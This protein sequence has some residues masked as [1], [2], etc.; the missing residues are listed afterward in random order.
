MMEFKTFMKGEILRKLRKCD[1]TELLLWISACQLPPVNRERAAIIEYALGSLVSQNFEKKSRR[2]VSRDFIARIFWEAYVDFENCSR[3]SEATKLQTFFPLGFLGIRGE[4]FPWQFAH[5]ALDRYGN[6]NE[7]MMKNLGF[8]IFDA[9]YFSKEIMKYSIRRALKFSFPSFPPFTKEE[10]YNPKYI[11]I[12]PKDTLDFW[13]ASIIFSKNELESLFPKDKH[14]KLKNYLKR[15]SVCLGDKQTQIKDPLDFNILTARPF[16]KV[17]QDFILVIPRLLWYALSTTFH[18]DFLSDATYRGKYID[19]K[20]KIAERR[21]VTCFSKIFASD[22]LFPRVRYDEHKGSPDVDLIVREEDTLLFVEC[23]AKWITRK[24]KKG[25]PISIMNDLRSSVEKCANQLFR[26]LQ[27]YQKGKF[28]ET[29][30]SHDTEKLLPIIVVDD[31]IPGLDF[32]IRLCDFLQKSRPYIINIYDL[33]I[34]TDLISK[35]D[36]IDFA[37]KRIELSKVGR[38]F[39]ADEIDYFVLYRMHGFEKYTRLLEKSQSELHYIGHLENIYPTYYVEHF[40]KFIDDPALSNLIKLQNLD[41]QIG[42]S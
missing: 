38:I 5:A 30:G 8:T 14:E 4:A 31:Y 40:M 2:K 26:A 25:D 34:I 39:A 24:A 29:L 42:W 23:T 27:S 28:K 16:V 20:G 36:F 9:V 35:E 10:Y 7:W 13:K 41:W 11:M 37:S 17:D 12:P 19:E 21:M 1:P 6:H 18:F 3:F 15:M 22:N 33:D 32:I